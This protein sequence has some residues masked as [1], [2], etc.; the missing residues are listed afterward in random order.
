MYFS[1]K[2][3]SEGLF[4]NF[5][6][7][8]PAIWNATFDSRLAC[9]YNASKLDMISQAYL[10]PKYLFTKG[11]EQWNRRRLSGQWSRL[12]TARG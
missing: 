10:K 2:V 1:T 5:L 7:K 9:R 4:Q 3:I 11:W 8:A 12:T 6:L